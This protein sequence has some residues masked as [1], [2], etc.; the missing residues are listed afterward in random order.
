MPNPLQG[1]RVKDLSER[2]SEPG[3]WRRARDAVSY[4]FTG[5]INNEWFSPLRP[6]PPIVPRAATTECA[7]ACALG[8]VFCLNS[9]FEPIYQR[10]CDD[11]NEL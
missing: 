6:L 4:I 9:R 10:P 11:M 8:I 5:E 1:A 7:C 3:L 2:A